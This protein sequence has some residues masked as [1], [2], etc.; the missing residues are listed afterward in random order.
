MCVCVCEVVFVCEVVC[1][2]VC[3]VTSVIY[4]HVY[5]Q[6]KE[7]KFSVMFLALQ[8]KLY[9]LQYISLVSK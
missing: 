4:R 3:V 8:L 5:T 7:R 9:L 6:Q 2:C 1:V